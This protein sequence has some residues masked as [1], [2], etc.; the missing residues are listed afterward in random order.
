MRGIKNIDDSGAQGLKHA[1]VGLSAA[2]F[3]ALLALCW[4]TVAWKF[5]NHEVTKDSPATAGEG[6]AGG[7]VEE[8][9]VATEQN[10]SSGERTRSGSPDSVVA[11]AKM[12]RQ[13]SEL[14]LRSLRSCRSLDNIDMP[15]RGL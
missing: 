2:L 4:V 6:Q 13:V 14:S 5:L 3:L 8:G 9:E 12:K 1:C 15:P 11:E 7:G 10:N